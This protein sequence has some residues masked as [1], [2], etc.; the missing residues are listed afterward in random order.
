MRFISVEYPMGFEQMGALG[1]FMNEL[2]GPHCSN[3]HLVIKKIKEALD[4]NSS[5]DSWTYSGPSEK[6]FPDEKSL[7]G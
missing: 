1:G 7:F 4:P 2:F 3:Y 5:C 6:A